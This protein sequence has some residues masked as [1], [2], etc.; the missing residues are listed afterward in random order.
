MNA[1][2]NLTPENSKERTDGYTYT[3]REKHT[4][5]QTQITTITTTTNNNNSSSNNNK[6]TKI[7]SHS[8][9]VSFNINGLNSQ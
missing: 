5:A 9:L 8:L 2:N 7:N 6:I 4:W 3:Q 1:V